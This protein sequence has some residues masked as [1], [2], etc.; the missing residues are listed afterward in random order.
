MFLALCSNIWLRASASSPV[1]H[2]LGT[3]RRKTGE[4]SWIIFSIKSVNQ[5]GILGRAKCQKKEGFTFS[6]FMEHQFFPSICTSYKPSAFKTLITGHFRC[7]YRWHLI[8][9]PPNAFLNVR[10]LF[11][12]S[13]SSRSIG[14]YHH[15]HISGVI[16]LLTFGMFQLSDYLVWRAMS[17][18]IKCQ[19]RWLPPLSSQWLTHL[20]PCTGAL[21]TH[22]SS[23]SHWVTAL[24]ASGERRETER[25]QS[26]L[27][28]YRQPAL[29]P[30]DLIITWPVERI[31]HE[32]LSHTMK[33]T[34]RQDCML[35]YK[36]CCS[37]SAN[38]GM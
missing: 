30:G 10:L 25:V 33:H 24:S 17:C 3:L 1:W 37:C 14:S 15:H 9:K 11:K 21:L 6:I 18:G 7:D 29:S 32:A 22:Q 12:C 13:I 16:E 8:W 38:T 4:K 35:I 23:F 36:I 34:C 2:S 19:A 28:F 5:S 27:L 26:H 31:A 20:F